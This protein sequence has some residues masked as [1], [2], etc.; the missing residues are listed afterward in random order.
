MIAAAS[1]L[2]PNAVLGASALITV[3]IEA[4]GP[5]RAARYGPECVV[6]AIALAIAWLSRDRLDARV[7]VALA[8][9]LPA[10]LAVVHL[11]RGIAGDG[12]V[13]TVY[14]SEGGSLLHATYPHS[15]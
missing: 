6:A 11:A 14:P 8:V 1:R 15:E 5:H 2:S 3:L 10:A 12:D 9:A 7:V 4:L 13:A